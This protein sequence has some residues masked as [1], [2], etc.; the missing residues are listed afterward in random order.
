MKDVEDSRCSTLA[1]A[2]FAAGDRRFDAADIVEAAWFRGDLPPLWQEFLAGIAGERRAEEDGLEPEG[3]ALQNLSEDVRYKHDLIT[4]EE[5]ETWLT[6]RN[7]TLDNLT[8]YAH[9]RFWREHTAA[10]ALPADLGYLEATPEQREQ[11]IGDLFF[12]GQLDELARQLSWRVAGSVATIPSDP[13]LS[14]RLEAER[15]RFSQR[16]ASDPGKLSQ[17]LGQLGRDGP[18]FE[19][20]LAQESS[21]R[22]N[23]DQAST[24]ENRA[25]TL[26]NLRLPLTCFE[27]ELMDLE[28]ADAVSEA[29]FCL[30]TD[31]L[32]MDELAGQEHNRVERREIL[33]EEF[34]EE[35]QQQFLSAE[36]GHVLPL[37]T[38]DDRFQVCRVVNKREPALADE[39]VL[40]RVD[41][42]L[43]AGH[44]ENLVTKQI[45]WLIGPNAAA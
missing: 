25:R 18:W 35:L 38:T 33:L 1:T 24:T 2:V 19:S 14:N 26:A 45:V 23:C 6:A 13:A 11:F 4:A 22:W 31:G 37:I 9:R 29:C 28:S 7:L 21:H 44:F 5:T 32:S 41:A 16:T 27:V 30:S 17:W 20:Q 8:A 3:E 34:P 39:K 10:P 12:G 42:E 15:A 40:A 43:L 36:S